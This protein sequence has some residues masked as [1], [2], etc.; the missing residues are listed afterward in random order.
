VEQ[1]FQDAFG[2]SLGDWTARWAAREWE[3]SFLAKYRGPR[4]LL[5]VT[6][7]PTWPFVVIAWTGVALLIASWV[8]R[9][10]TA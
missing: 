5:G 2:E 4:I 7:E 10:R 8:A 1:A 3:A 9:R 6:L